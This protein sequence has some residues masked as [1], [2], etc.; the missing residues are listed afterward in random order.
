LEKAI[1]HQKE[2][3]H[4]INVKRHLDIKKLIS[5]SD[6]TERIAEWKIEACKSNLRGRRS[7]VKIFVVSC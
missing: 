7:R 4:D 1:R 3:S 5:L 6:L 2:E